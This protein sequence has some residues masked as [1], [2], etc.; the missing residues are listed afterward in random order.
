MDNLKSL[1]KISRFFFSGYFSFIASMASVIGL[2]IAF[3]S[4]KN[5]AIIALI[6]I[7]IFLILLLIRLFFFLNELLSQS[8]NNGYKK[9]AT[10][11]RY[12]TSDAKYIS[13]EEHRFI[14]CK[15]IILDEYSHKFYWTGSNTPTIS[16]DLQLIDN[17][18]LNETGFS[19]CKLKFKRPLTLNESGL[20]N[21]KMA[22]NDS[23][24]VSGTFISQTIQDSIHMVNYRVELPYK[25]GI[26]PD[27]Q[28]KRKKRGAPDISPATFLTNVTFDNSSK[29]YQYTL[30]DPEIGYDY[31]LEWVR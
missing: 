31:I 9:F 3:A 29:A 21:I 13:Y 1:N 25:D 23:N 6:S 16:S 19:I 15:S 18:I 4:D 22:I 20:I 12:S 8:T 28:F 30:I 2:I 7:I 24:Q 5:K 11:I 26:V 14:Q 10:Y 17:T 27:A